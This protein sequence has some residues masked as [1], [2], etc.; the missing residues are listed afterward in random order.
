[1]RRV[2]VLLF[3]LIALAM[4]AC[5]DLIDTNPTTSTPSS[6][7]SPEPD[8]EEEKSD[9]DSR[10]EDAAQS[11]S[12][13]NQTAQPPTGAEKTITARLTG[14]S[15]QD[16]TPPGSADICCGKIHSKAG[17]TGTYADPITT[18]V[19]GSGGRGMET[20][21]GT[22]IYVPDLKR[23]VIV[24]DSGA[25]KGSKTHFDVWVGGQ[26]FPKSA[27]DKC[28]NSFTGDHTVILNPTPGKPV[29]VGPLTGPN[30]CVI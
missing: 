30:G 13:V 5:Q 3:A 18:A 14:Y 1:M 6:S 4:T 9:E 8:A 25:T 7:S 10:D 22:R 29:T 23:Y 21:A 19:P 28:M 26:G 17:G 27:S 24:E 12:S 15:W 16:N 11:D 20:P 2:L